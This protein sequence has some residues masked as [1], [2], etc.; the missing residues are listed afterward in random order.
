MRI[1]KT[2]LLLTIIVV[3]L[4][5]FSL[6]GKLSN[7]HFLAV[8]EGRS[9]EPT[10]NTG[11]IVFMIPISDPREIN[12]G[13]VI[14]FKRPNGELIIHRV[15]EIKIYKDSYYYVTKGDN[16]PIPD[17]P[18]NPGEPGISFRSV[19][20]KVLSLGKGVVIKIPYVGIIPLIL[21]K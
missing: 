7:T 5:G 8:V 10:L 14:V 19:I 18:N 1:R 3:F 9:M 6:Y 20:G 21:L 2:D 4:L 11:D 13:D 16:N 12:V 15:I 17:P